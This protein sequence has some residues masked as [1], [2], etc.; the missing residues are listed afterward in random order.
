[1]SRQ[2]GKQTHKFYRQKRRSALCYV[3]RTA[4]PTDLAPTTHGGGFIMATGELFPT[5]TEWLHGHSYGGT[6]A[7]VQLCR[8]KLAS[9]D[10]PL[11][12]CLTF[13]A[14]SSLQ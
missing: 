4:S 2:R 3:G 10:S 14:V 1:M 11:K 6:A 9:A 12:T 7:L 8:R 5:G 13:Q